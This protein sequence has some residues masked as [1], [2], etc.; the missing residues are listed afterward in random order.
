MKQSSKQKVIDI[1][2]E[3][4]NILEL[5]RKNKE[6][7]LLL[8]EEAI[9]LVHNYLADA[10]QVLV[11]GLYDE[12]KWVRIRSAETLLRKALPDKKTK[13][14]TGE[15]GGPI[16]IEEH[17]KRTAVI[18]IIGILDELGFDELRERVA[19]GRERVLE[20]GCGTEGEAKT[21]IQ[22]PEETDQGRE[23]PRQ[24]QG[25]GEGSESVIPVEAGPGEG[26]PVG[27]GEEGSRRSRRREVY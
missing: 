26:K 12:D 25:P 27:D 4:N 23:R 16:Q 6:K 5:K 15:G 18:N 3:T 19:N 20:I 7:Q 21:G 22:T 10:V 13:E 24:D 17:D 1:S 2:P 8:Q 11:D 14:I 9:D